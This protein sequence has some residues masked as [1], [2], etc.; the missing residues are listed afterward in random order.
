MSVGSWIWAVETAISQLL[1]AGYDVTGCDPSES[2]IAVARESVPRARFEVA[3]V[4]DDPGRLGRAE[5]DA[6]VAMEVIEHLYLPR[7]LPAFARVVLK[8]RGVLVV[9]MPYHGYLKNLAISI[10]GGWDA[11]FSPLW[12]GGHVKFFSPRTIQELMSTAGFE[13]EEFRG[14]G[15]V[16]WLWKSMVLVFRR[17][18]S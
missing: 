10:R 17:T 13:L 8:R 7:A 16:P 11:H 5:F 2:G 15:R 18:E 12:D 9:T 1:A 3:G 14:A 4:Y 6:V